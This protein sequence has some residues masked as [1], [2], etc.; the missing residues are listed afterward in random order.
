MLDAGAQGIIIPMVNSAEEAVRAVDATKYPPLG[1]RSHGP[2]IIGGHFRSLGEE[3]YPT[4]NDTNACIPMIETRDAVENLMRF[5]CR[6]SRRHIRR[7]RRP[8]IELR[9]RPCV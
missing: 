4:A 2:T 3:Y 8:L 6:W 5:G 9:I 7:S 1:Q